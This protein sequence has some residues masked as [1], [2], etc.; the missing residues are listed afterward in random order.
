MARNA[1]VMGRWQ[2]HVHTLCLPCLDSP[3]PPDRFCAAAAVSS[4]AGPSARQP[5]P[6]CTACASS[7][8]GADDVS[9]SSGSQPQAVTS[10][11]R[12]PGTDVRTR[13]AT[14]HTRQIRLPHAHPLQCGPPTPRI[15][16]HNA[17]H[18]TAQHITARSTHAPR[19][20]FQ[21]QAMLGRACSHAHPRPH[22]HTFAPIA[23]TGDAAPGGHHRRCGHRSR[24][25]PSLKYRPAPPNQPL[26]HA[27]CGGHGTAQHS[28]LEPPQSH[29]ADTYGHTA[30]R[31]QPQPYG[32]HSVS[33]K[34]LTDCASGTTAPC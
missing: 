34:P 22:I 17:Q 33:H 1:G 6:A 24:V 26:Q 12:P 29:F 4:A 3:R 23:A 25:R 8:A 19:L 32:G 28:G 18:G 2:P 10:G 16:G 21:T 15:R 13:A 9:C 31:S 5:I 14:L 7:G 11:A 27:V 30:H 20:S